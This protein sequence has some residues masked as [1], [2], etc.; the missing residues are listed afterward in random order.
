MQTNKLL[1]S[2]AHPEP[3]AQNASLPFYRGGQD[4]NKV[5]T[6]NGAVVNGDF[7]RHMMGGPRGVV[8]HLVRPGIHVIE[9]YHSVNCIVVEGDT[10][11]IV[12]ESGT[13]FGHGRDL[14]A[15]IRGFSDKPV[16]ALVYSHHHYIGGAAGLL[17]D[18]VPENVQVFAHP[19]TEHLDATTSSL[20]GPMQLR[21]SGIQFG[22]YL[23]EKGADARLGRGDKHFD[24]P[25]LNAAA[26][27]PVTHAVADG[28]VVTVD[29]VVMR[30][31]HIIGD[32]RDSLAIEFP[33][34]DAV[35][36]NS[37]LG[38]MA[39][40]LYTLRGDF[41]RT[42]DELIAA[43]DLLRNLDR[44]Y[45]I[46]VHG[47]P[48]TDRTSAQAALTAHRDAYAF[49]WNQSLRA[50]NRGMTPDEMVASIRLPEHLESNPLLYPGYV[51]WEYGIRGVYRG[52]VGW[53]SEDGADLHPP[54]RAELGS[55]LVDGF[56]GEEPFLDRARQAMAERKYNLVVSLMSHLMAARPESLAARQLKADALRAMAQGTRTG[57][58]T[59]NFLLTEALHLEGETD[60][61]R[62]SPKSFFAAA[63][64]ETLAQRP[65]QEQVKLLEQHVDPNVAPA[66]RTAVAFRF[67][68]HGDCALVF[69]P[70]IAEFRAGMPD[71]AAVELTLDALTMSRLTLRHISLM[72]A[73]ASSAVRASG[74]T[75]LLPLL[76]RVLA[77]CG[78]AE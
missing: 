41:F 7:L 37:A 66:L 13:R 30:F 2:G 78:R 50:I 61:H 26:P 4:H 60:W 16:R 14:R 46:P 44:T 1:V 36:A 65:P 9:G 33:E 48:Y 21:R 69:R 24:D 8:V 42:P 68:G 73:V 54:S 31:H 22:A 45:V 5:I 71:K 53:Y 74:D 35:V 70:G 51:D 34:L 43:L 38:P 72:D 25:H 20:L 52:L 57:I 11:L 23:P 27:L 47:S 29:G 58:Q 28:E 62:P 15:L 18:E 3:V 40:P 32:T 64:A 17:G 67:E 59:R 55:V 56:G 12:I 75:A 76:E 77:L 19:L 49:I 39:Y 63:T 10:G 6:P